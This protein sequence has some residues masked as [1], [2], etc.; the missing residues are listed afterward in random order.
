M[1]TRSACRVL[2]CLSC[3]V[4]AG[5]ATSPAGGDGG[6]HMRP[7]KIEMKPA[8]DKLVELI[9]TVGFTGGCCF[10]LTTYD[11]AATLEVPEGVEVV[12]GPEPPRYEQIVGPP[13]GVKQGFAEFRWRLR[14]ADEEAVYPIKV[15]L[16]TKNSGTVEK[17]CELAKPLPCNVSQPEVAHPA[18]SNT[19][20][21]VKV[22]VASNKEDRFVS[23][24]TLYYV[25]GL[26]SGVSH[27]R[28]EGRTLAYGV[29][30]T[31]AARQ[32]QPLQMSRKY[33]PT[34]WRASL[35]GRPPGT[36]HYWIVAKD[37][38]GEL[39]TSPVCELWVVD[40]GETRLALNL[41][42]WGLAL[43]V[44][45]AAMALVGRRRAA[46]PLLPGLLA[47][48]ASTAS[49][50]PQHGDAKDV[51]RASARLLVG[52][53]CL[54]AAALVVATLLSPDHLRHLLALWRGS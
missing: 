35:P 13:G 28:A 38:A 15:R 46:I 54:T 23:K 8:P 40:L 26:P 43:A 24:V 50:P 3:F 14:K 42:G 21:P 51:R 41:T 16:T 20:T 6:A 12:S 17:R 49:L 30:G 4:L 11:V 22:D 32:G 52:M 5:L 36:V 48:G 53:L 27:L 34:V 39:T 31:N 9:V 25:S 29:T 7:P 10:T 1:S 37:S 2:I 33:E 47:L 19:P 45:L 18:P 44:A